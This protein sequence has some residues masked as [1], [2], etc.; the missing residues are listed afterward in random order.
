MTVEQIRLNR[1]NFVCI[2]REL[3]IS[4][5]EGSNPLQLLQILKIFPGL[6]SIKMAMCYVD[7]NYIAKL[8]QEQFPL[9][10][11][12]NIKSTR[13]SKDTLPLLLSSFPNL[14]ILDHDLRFLTDRDL[15]IIAA[16]VSLHYKVLFT[17]AFKC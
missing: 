10:E 2:C 11:E 4:C 3:D 12:L 9:V 8:E 5:T 17:F 6:R 14:R 16:K 13:L 1:F 7:D 15:Q